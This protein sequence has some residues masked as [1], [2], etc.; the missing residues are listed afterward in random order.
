MKRDLWK[1]EFVVA[2]Q[3]S[4]GIN[5]YQGVDLGTNKHRHKHKH[6][7]RTRNNMGQGDMTILKKLGHRQLIN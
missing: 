5:H 2:K 3:S 1:L 7:R 6:G 4:D